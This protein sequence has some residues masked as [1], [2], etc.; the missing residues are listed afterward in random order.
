[1]NHARLSEVNQLLRWHTV[2]ALCSIVIFGAMAVW[3]DGQGV[4]EVLVAITILTMVVI[5]PAS[6][7]NK[8]ERP[9]WAVASLIGVYLFNAVVASLIIPEIYPVIMLVPIIGVVTTLPYLRDRAFLM[10]VLWS[11]ATLLLVTILGVAGIH[12]IIIPMTPSLILGWIIVIGTA[13]ELALLGILLWQYKHRLHRAQDGLA[14]AHEEVVASN[15]DLEKKVTERT[16]ELVL[17]LEEVRRA[18]RAKDEFLAAMSHELRTPLS[19][20]TGYAGLLQHRNTDSGKPDDTVATYLDRIQVNGRILLQLINDILD[21]AKIHSGKLDLRFD[22]VDVVLLCQDVVRDTVVHLASGVRLRVILPDVPVLVWA[23]VFRI[24]QVL[25]NLLSNATKFTEQ[26]EIV[27][28]VTAD[29][30]TARITVQDTGIGIAPEH[31]PRIFEAFEQVSATGDVLSRTHGGTGLGLPISRSLLELQKGGLHVTSAPGVGSTF[32][33]ELPLVTRS[34]E[35]PIVAIIDDDAEATRFLHEHLTH[36]GIPSMIVHNPLHAMDEL[37]A[38]P[39]VRVVLLDLQMP[40]LHGWDL[41]RQLRTDP[42]TAALKVVIC[43][44]DQEAEQIYLVRG[45]MDVLIKPVTPD[46]VRRVVERLVVPDVHH[47]RER[48][49]LVVDDNIDARMVATLILAQMGFQTIEAESG[50]AAI[51]HLRAS[52]TIGLV[53]L[54]LMLPGISGLTVLDTIR[55]ELGL[56][57]PV[58]VV[59]AKTLTPVEEARLQAQQATIIPKHAVSAMKFVEIIR[60]IQ[61]TYYIPE[62]VSYE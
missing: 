54:D 58:V 9:D 41:L 13:L 51:N 28:S 33:M 44:A 31:L 17:A 42:R 18:G 19:S 8:Q 15:T 21:L 7:L 11:F 30:G 12:L 3:I 48:S 57:I 38:Y 47:I 10:V 60:D 46:A 61:H 4:P 14:R 32:T 35:N 37:R 2:I 24:R 1:M 27:V 36:A 62:G 45:A 59:S 25:L 39:S 49:V 55:N 52:D 50:E 20:I 29:A 40:T 22:T 56:T 43:S 16:N 23:D 6:T 53:L 26:G 5:V 34:D